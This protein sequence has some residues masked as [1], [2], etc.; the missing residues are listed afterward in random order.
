MGTTV[1]LAELAGEGV[2]VISESGIKTRDDVIRLRDAGVKGILV[3]ETLMR[4]DDVAQRVE[5]LLGPLA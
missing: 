5:D 4:C 1:R 2:P 3:G